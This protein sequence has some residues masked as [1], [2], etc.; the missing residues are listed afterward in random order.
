MNA[1]LADQQ[2]EILVQQLVDSSKEMA[3]RLQISVSEAI[4]KRVAY[5]EKYA[6]TDT[7]ATAWYL[8]GQQAKKIID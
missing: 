7:E 2:N 1:R 4:D 3:A 5:Y 8:R 6:I